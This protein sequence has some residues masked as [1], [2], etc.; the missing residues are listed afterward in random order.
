M[1]A[2]DVEVIGAAA[3]ILENPA[4]GAGDPDALLTPDKVPLEI[5][6]TGAGT[7]MNPPAS[8]PFC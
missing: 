1:S 4:L 3:P 6:W 8:E 2:V 5:V 7:V